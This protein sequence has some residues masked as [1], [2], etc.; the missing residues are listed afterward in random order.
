MVWLKLRALN[1]NHTS[2]SAT[3]PMLHEPMLCVAPTDEPGVYWQVEKEFM[4][5]APAQSSLPGVC[6]KT[7]IEG[8][9]KRNAKTQRKSARIVSGKSEIV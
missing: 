6:A 9:N 2:S 4:A 8:R 7:N 5:T 3:P 1:L